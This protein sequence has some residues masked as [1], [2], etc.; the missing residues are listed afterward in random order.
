MECPYC[1]E[2]VRHEAM[3]C[4]HCSR[5]LRRNHHA[6]I[7]ANRD[8]PPHQGRRS[9]QLGLLRSKRGM[10]LCQFPKGSN[11]LKVSVGSPRLQSIFIPFVLPAV[12]L[13]FH[14]I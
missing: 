11:F 5:D 6:G 9:D 10:R 2:T 7:N 4:K 13:A 1:A 3:T 8:M 12:L 14:G